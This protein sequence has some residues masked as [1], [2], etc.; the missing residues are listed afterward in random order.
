[1]EYERRER[2]LELAEQLAQSQQQ[3]EAREAFREA[4]R[5]QADDAQPLLRL[6]HWELEWGDLDAAHQSLGQALEVNPNDPEIHLKL[7]LL[8]HQSGQL[9]YALQYFR[10]A[11]KLAPEMAQGW[12]QL[13]RL[14]QQLGR[15]EQAAEAYQEALRLTPQDAQSHNSLGLLYYFAS[16][17]APAMRHLQHA[18]TL[19]PQKGIYHLNLAMA[20]L[21]GEDTHQQA[22]DELA[23]AIQQQPELA[24]EVYQIGE[25]FLMRNQHHL[26]IPFYELSLKGQVNAY[27]THLKLAQCAERECQM[28][29]ALDHC[30][31]ALEIEPERWLLKIYAGLLL[32]LIYQSQEEIQLWRDRFAQNLQQMQA[33]LSQH[34]Y[35][36][37]VQSVTI[38]SPAFQL[39][40]QG[41]DNRVLLEQMSE[42]W[43]RLLNLPQTP[44]KSLRPRGQ[45]KRIGFLSSFFFTHSV[46]G[47]YLGL[48]RELARTQRFELHAFSVGAR[49]E[50][51]VTQEIQELCHWHVLDAHQ[52]LPKLARAVL[53]ADL[54]L[55]IYPELGMEPITYLLAQ[56]RLAPVQA[57]MFG[58]PCTSGIRNLDFYLS[59]DCIEAPGAEADY[60]ETLVRLPGCP[61][62][63]RRPAAP[64]Q[65]FVR[66]AHNLPDE[67]HLY[68]LSSTLFKIHPDHDPLFQEI[69]SAD[70]QARILLIQSP[71]SRWHQVLQRRFEKHMGPELAERIHFLPWMAREDFFA[72]L[73]EA[74]VVLD[75]LH[76]GAG[77]VAYQALGLGVPMLTRP[78]QLMRSRTT[79]GLYQLLKISGL[80][81]QDDTEFVQ[82]CLRMAQDPDWRRFKRQEVAR[83]AS[84]LFEPNDDFRA[85]AEI[86]DRLRPAP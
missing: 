1:M 14:L 30:R 21:Q 80:S 49:V 48:M 71:S 13:G 29:M 3:T 63:Y 4:W 38:Y 85:L 20:L 74:E 25:H 10:S 33:E 78:G 43:T 57:L 81:A 73:L 55:L 79:A 22:L 35:P 47:V 32:P 70:P 18:V 28:Q 62:L 23:A 6:A 24:Q 69:L 59:P 9:L 34:K 44:R 15:E 37:S 42:L 50:D 54:D 5:L 83:K 76:F 11:L 8:F 17:F 61:F 16:D 82:L 64:A 77:N 65:R 46:T 75:S 26:A 60:T 19:K 53:D 36:P 2:F 68:L 45:K 56:A 72:L 66:S 86:V 41:L 7:G 84:R 40:Y 67:A 39:A 58:H 12:R 52:S 27:E 31:A 51:A